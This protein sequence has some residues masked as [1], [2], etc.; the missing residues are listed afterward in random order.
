M[1]HLRIFI[2]ILSFVG[3][4]LTTYA[5]Q[6]KQ[7]KKTNHKRDYEEEWNF[8][9]RFAIKLTPSSLLDPYGALLPVG[10]EYYLDNKYGFNL[11]F[12][13][14][15]YYALN[16]KRFDNYKHINSDF[17]VRADIRHYFGYSKNSRLF[18]GGEM[19]YRNQHMSLKDSYFHFINNHCYEFAEGQAVKDIFGFGFFMGRTQ[20]L[21]QH[22][23]LETH[24]GIGLRIINMSPQM[25]FSNSNYYFKGSFVSL[26]PP[27]E[28]RVGDHDLNIYVPFAIKLTYLF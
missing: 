28:D 27:N 11:E 8:N 6:V 21:S 9:D 7:N 1:M 15:L 2:S 10:I 5:Q 4:S 17:K 16:N 26:E 12:G 14:P 3:F 23:F 18:Y 13:F 25:D 19:F 24:L 22:F 20:K